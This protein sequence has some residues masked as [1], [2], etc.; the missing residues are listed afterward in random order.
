M[1]SK[2]RYRHLRNGIMDE[3]CPY[4]ACGFCI[5]GKRCKFKHTERE[6]CKNFLL[7]YCPMGAKCLYAHPS[8]LTSEEEKKFALVNSQF[9]YSIYRQMSEDPI[10]Q[11]RI[12]VS[13]VTCHKCNQKGHYANKCPLSYKYQ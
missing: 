5:L 12:S 1:F 13:Q 11:R 9:Y 3:E 2:C 4:Y 7:G 8:P 10:P 6:L